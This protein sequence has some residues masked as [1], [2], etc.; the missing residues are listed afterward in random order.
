[1]GLIPRR[2]TATLEAFVNSH[3]A[4]RTDVKARTQILYF[5]TRGSLWE[6]IDPKIPLADITPGDAA[7]WRLYMLGAGLLGD[8]TVRRRC[9]RAVFEGSRS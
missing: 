7:E 2:E 3:M 8:N 9:G 1:M 6:F 4:S 5:Q